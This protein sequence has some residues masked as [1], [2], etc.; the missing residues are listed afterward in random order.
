[1]GLRQPW[2]AL[3][4]GAVIAAAVPLPAPAQG[5]SAENCRATRTI[6]AAAIAGRKA[7]E[8]PQAVGAR[9]ASDAGGIAARYR[10]T[11]PTLVDL[12]Y[13]LDPGL[14][15]EATAAQFETMCLSYQG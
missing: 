4:M 12:V 6:V 11:V 8:T 5:L 10:A 15:T 3:C 13:K 14:L 7:G 2:V 1:M 9:L